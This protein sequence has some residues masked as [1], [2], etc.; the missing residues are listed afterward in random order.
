MCPTIPA[1]LQFLNGHNMNWVYIIYGRLRGTHLVISIVANWDTSKRWNSLPIKFSS[2]HISVALS[3]QCNVHCPLKSSPTMFL[4]FFFL[5]YAF[6]SHP[7][8]ILTFFPYSEFIKTQGDGR[9]WWVCRE[10]QLTYV[11][12]SKSWQD[13]IGQFSVKGQSLIEYSQYIINGFN[14]NNITIFIPPPCPNTCLHSNVQHSKARNCNG[15]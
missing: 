5:L 13:N 11:W 14:L 4:K 10:C 1:C 15:M 3:A 6:Q 12:E 7:S 8:A 9:K 2:N